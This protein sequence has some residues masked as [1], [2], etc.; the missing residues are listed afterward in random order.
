MPEEYDRFE[1]KA[2][3]NTRVARPKSHHHRDAPVCASCSES[4]SGETEMTWIGSV[5]EEELELGW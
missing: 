5:T 4:Q 2:C 3:E 1:C